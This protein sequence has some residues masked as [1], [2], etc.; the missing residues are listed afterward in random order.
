MLPFATTRSL[1]P[2]PRLATWDDVNLRL[3]VW[4]KGLLDYAHGTAWQ[5]W[6]CQYGN[7]VYQPTGL[8]L[9]TR[10]RVVIQM[11]FQAFNI[12][13]YV[14]SYT[15]TTPPLLRGL[16]GSL[17]AAFTDFPIDH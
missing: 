4:F 17:V 9:I 5:D 3:T 6:S 1:S 14:C 7:S 16:S 10:Y 8:H 11:A 13:A 2:D 15:A 12:P